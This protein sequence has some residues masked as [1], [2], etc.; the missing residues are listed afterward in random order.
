MKFRLH[1]ITENPITSKQVALLCS[2]QRNN[3]QHFNDFGSWWHKISI[4]EIIVPEI[5]V[6]DVTSLKV[7]EVNDIEKTLCFP[8][9]DCLPLIKFSFRFWK[10]ESN[11]WHNNLKNKLWHRQVAWGFHSDDWLNECN[12]LLKYSRPWNLQNFLGCSENYINGTS[13]LV[14]L[15][16]WEAWYQY[17]Q[18]IMEKNGFDWTKFYRDLTQSVILPLSIKLNGKIRFWG[19]NLRK[20]QV[21]VQGDWE[22]NQLDIIL[23]RFLDHLVAFLSSVLEGKYI[24]QSLS[25]DFSQYR[26][27]AIHF[28]IGLSWSRAEFDYQSS[29]VL[30]NLGFADKRVQFTDVSNPRPISIED[31]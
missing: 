16:H 25:K 4:G 28:W 8:S 21:Q 11:I 20:V 24:T 6:L 17:E 26:D 10:E 13:D 2:Q 12:L 18:I 23:Q 22:Q 5:L 15:L 3:H 30:N 27:P 14:G 19:Y 31:L 9:V 7:D 29:Q 1:V